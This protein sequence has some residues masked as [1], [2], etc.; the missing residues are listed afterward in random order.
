MAG[1][2]PWN[3]G[4]LSHNPPAARHFASLPTALRPTNILC[5]PAQCLALVFD[6]AG[7]WFAHARG[8]LEAGMAF[9]Q[10]PPEHESRHRH[11]PPGPPSVQRFSRRAIVHPPT[12][13][14]HRQDR[15]QDITAACSMGSSLPFFVSP[16]RQ[17]HASRIVHDFS[18]FS[19]LS[20][21][22]SQRAVSLQQPGRS[23]R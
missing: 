2:C 5:E 7:L 17:L 9:Q 23:C 14:L 10:P 4:R 12:Q 1:I 11:I 20:T 21:F 6:C 8:E 3:R 18:R 16:F 15:R 19:T 13:P 22:V